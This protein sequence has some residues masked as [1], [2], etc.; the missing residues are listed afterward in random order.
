MFVAMVSWATAW[1]SAKV[2]GQYVSFYNLVFLRFFF[3][4][5]SLLPFVL[6]RKKTIPKIG[7]LKYIFIP[8]ILFFVYNIF[9]F[10]GTY[11]GLAGEGGVLV[12]TLNPLITI[13]L[14]SLIRKKI[15]VND[16]FGVCLGLIGGFIIM[17]LW[18]KG[19]V[20]I[21]HSNNLYFIFCSI[22]WGV[23]TIFFNYSM[24]RID[25]YVFIF[26][27]YFFTAIISWPFTDLGDLDFK[28][29]DLKFYLNFFL[30]SIGAMSF[31]TSVYIYVTPL[32]GPS[33]VSVFIFCVP[34]IAMSTAYVFLNEPFSFNVGIGGLLSLVAIYIVNK[35]KSSD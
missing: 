28:R 31:G 24:N 16:I 17:D 21:I 2:I 12:T 22:A 6:L 1:S 30:V 8:S 3:G 23:M 14:M 27:C 29:L 10:K 9:F 19:I 33:K 32:L 26:L 5:V 7:D 25:P 4:F 35:N 13:I 34:F 20:S 11:Y 18:N 15:S